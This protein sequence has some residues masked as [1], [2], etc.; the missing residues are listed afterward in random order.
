MN[1][2]LKGLKTLCRGMGIPHAIGCLD[3]PMR[4]Q[5]VFG[6]LVVQGW[7]L[8]PPG[9]NYELEIHF[10]GRP[11]QTRVQRCARPD[12]TDRYP[13]LRA[14]NPTPGIRAAVD[15]SFV[16]SGRHALALVGRRGARTRVLATTT[17]QV[18]KGFREFLAHLFLAGSG[19]EIGALNKPLSVPSGCRV[20]Y[21]DRMDANGLR[22]HYPELEGEALAPVDRIDDGETLAGVAPASQDFIIAN[23]VLEH[24]QDPIG[25]IE[26]YLQL[27]RPGGV[28]Y[29]GVPDKRFTFDV[30]RPVTPLEHLY[31]DYEEGPAWSY[32]DHIREWVAFVKNLTG[33]AAE[34]E[35]RRTVS[36]GY[37]IHFHVW[38][39]QEFLEMLVDIRRRLRLPFDM[40]ALLQEGFEI[41]SVL[42]KRR[43]AIAASG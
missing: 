34:V 9:R 18:P 8:E 15:A 6:P 27:L 20:S 35:V 26:R 19:L 31:R 23:Q 39:Q 3:L 1:M 11:V 25:T 32:L 2:Q 33:P 42:R 4:D 38:G 43:D 16:P 21:I 10:D 17:F 13:T 22:E 41:I 7:A 37:S 28:L 29:L 30:R 14:H 12:V 5:F 40:E 36:T 24:T